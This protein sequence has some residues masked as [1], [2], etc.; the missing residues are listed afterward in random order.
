MG[1]DV[2]RVD[3]RSRRSDR[4]ELT[5]LQRLVLAEVGSGFTLRQAAA[6]LNWSYSSVTSS[7]YDAKRLLGAGS[8]TQTVLL[9]IERG[10]IS[11]PT[12]AER[13]CFPL[14]K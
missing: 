5:R 8:L 11:S 13:Q 7:V 12:G 9:A 10:D 3:G 2:S 6:R 1:E 14:G 4:D